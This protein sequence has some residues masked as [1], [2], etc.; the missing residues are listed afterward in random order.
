MQGITTGISNALRYLIATATDSFHRYQDLA[1]IPIFNAF[2][3]SA[4]CLP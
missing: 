2:A 1:A 4:T 3:T